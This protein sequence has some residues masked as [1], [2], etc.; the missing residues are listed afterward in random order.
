MRKRIIGYRMRIDALLAC[1][2]ADVDW[3]AVLDEH[4]VQIGFFQHERLIHLLVTL[5]FALMELISVM[6]MV[7]TGQVSLAA[8]A[9]LFLVLLVPYVMHYYLLENETQRL[10]AQYDDLLAHLRDTEQ[11]PASTR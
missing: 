2:S 5:A 6:T 10:Y 3:Q 8:L 7:A 4:L 1:G 9:A 11:Y